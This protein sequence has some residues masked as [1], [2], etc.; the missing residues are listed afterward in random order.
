MSYMPLPRRSSGDAVSRAPQGAAPEWKQIGG[1]Q[2][3]SWN[4]DG[5]IY[6]LAGRLKRESLEKLL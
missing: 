5:N 6:V 4:R 1:W 3:A 2:T